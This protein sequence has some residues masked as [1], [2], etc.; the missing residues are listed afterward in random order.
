[1]LETTPAEYTE[2]FR[3][4]FPAYSQLITTYYF[5]SYFMGPTGNVYGAFLNINSYVDDGAVFYLNGTEIG[6]VRMPPG[7]P[8][9]S[10]VA[11]GTIP[12]EGTVDPFTFATTALVPGTNV[13]A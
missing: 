1:G 6:R 12:A 7:D 5:R 2:P 11:T 9:Y 13:L 8:A 3:T 10:T 4:V